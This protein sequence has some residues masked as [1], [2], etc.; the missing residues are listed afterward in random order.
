M[1]NI[2]YFQ[3]HVTLFETGEICKLDKNVS[4]VEKENELNESIVSSILTYVFGMGEITELV[5]L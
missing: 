1:K 3:G 5:K 4:R 2:V